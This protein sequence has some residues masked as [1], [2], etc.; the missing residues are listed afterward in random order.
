MTV[1]HGRKINFRRVQ[2][3]DVRR[4][5]PLLRGLIDVSQLLDQDISCLI[6]GN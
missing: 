1:C 4:I 5:K 6:I 2:L 3:N